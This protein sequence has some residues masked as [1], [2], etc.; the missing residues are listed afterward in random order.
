MNDR[1][2][3]AIQIAGAAGAAMSSVGEVRAVPGKGLEGDR[4]FSGV[5]TFSAPNPDRE[6][7]LIAKESL[8]AFEREHKIELKP[9]ETRRNLVTSGVALNDLVGEEFQVGAVT[10][11]G[12]RLCEPCDYLQSLTPKPVLQGLV[13]R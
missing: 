5:G 4:Y 13:H 8:E 12:L 11:K 10:L 7:T 9:A 3:V 1:L 6:I 2:L